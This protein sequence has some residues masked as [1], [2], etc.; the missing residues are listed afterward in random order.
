MQ[1]TA[2]EGTRSTWTSARSASHKIH[3]PI[4]CTNRS[5]TKLRNFLALY[6]HSGHQPLLAINKRVDVRLQRSRCQRSGHARIHYDNAWPRANR[7]AATVLEIVD[8]GVRR[9]EHGFLK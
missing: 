7:P 5:R 9:E 2:L 1:L 8:G 6:S 3:V 4:I